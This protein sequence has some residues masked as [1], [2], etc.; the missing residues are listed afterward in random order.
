[1]TSELN[2]NS[3]LCLLAGELVC[4]FPPA[5]LYYG[6]LGKPVLL[7]VPIPSNTHRFRLKK[8]NKILLQ[9]KGDDLAVHKLHENGVELFSSGSVKISH[10]LKNHSGE[11]HWE[12]FSSDGKVQCNVI[13]LLEIH[14]TH[15]QFRDHTGISLFFV[16][17]QH[18]ISLSIGV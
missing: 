12:T 5:P 6:I 18:Q 4:D 1:M 15:L 10:C 8:V 16:L 14:G 17:R 9:G 13:F 2:V 7:H 3:L 11:Y